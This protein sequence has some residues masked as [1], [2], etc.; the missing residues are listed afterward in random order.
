[1]TRARFPE[2]TA[3]DDI[4]MS[5]IVLSGEVN[6]TVA[7]KLCILT[8]APFPFLSP[9]VLFPFLSPIYEALNISLFPRDVMN[10]FK[11][12]VERMKESRLQE[13]KKVIS[14]HLRILTY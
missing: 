1:M 11:T 2:G 4:P 3:L 13:K 6:V 8:M 7:G 12:S 14:G 10:F 9:V 5:S